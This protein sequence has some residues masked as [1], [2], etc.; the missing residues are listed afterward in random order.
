MSYLRPKSL[1]YV[2]DLAVRVTE[3][4]I[5]ERHEGYW[6]VETP[7]NPTFYWGN[8]LLFDET[9]GESDA[10]EMVDLFH[11]ELPAAKHVAIG[12][13]ATRHDDARYAGLDKLGI[14]VEWNA[15]LTASQGIIAKNPDTD[16]EVR[17]I[18]TDEEW[19]QYIE[20]GMS[21]RPERFAETPYREYLEG[22]ISNKRS[23]QESGKAIWLG[24]VVDGVIAAS[25]GVYDC[26]DGVARYQKVETH[27]DHQ[28]KGLA[29]QLIHEAAALAAQDFGTQRLVIVADPEDY[30][31]TLYRKL[32]F[33]DTE[34]Q[35]QSQRQPTFN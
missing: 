8:F 16:I 7:N 17:R 14:E 18:K 23:A 22:G 30:A 24:A 26:G 34:F 4:S 5:V 6:R 27:L 35:L 3:G 31:I 12:I 29:S 15:V 2:S 21:V 13:D 20:V 10:Q 28:R 9:E 19:G 33:V 1:A 32:G 25:L 11:R